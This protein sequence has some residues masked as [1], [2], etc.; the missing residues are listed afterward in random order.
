MDCSV[1]VFMDEFLKFSTFLTILFVHGCPEGSSYSIDTQPALKHECHS[2]TT[3]R[4]IKYSPN[5]P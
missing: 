1:M 4:L 5:A 3:A 2:K